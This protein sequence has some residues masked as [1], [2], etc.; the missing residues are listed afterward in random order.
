MLGA[1]LAQA[2]S[3]KVRDVA[4]RAGPK[5]RSINVSDWGSELAPGPL[6]KSEGLEGQ[7]GPGLAKLPVVDLF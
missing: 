1:R 2:L 5:P 4:G 6:N 7:V 3:L